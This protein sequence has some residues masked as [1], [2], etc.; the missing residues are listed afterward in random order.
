M[1]IRKLR[2]AVLAFLLATNVFAA[3]RVESGFGVSGFIATLGLGP[4][5]ARP[6]DSQ[7]LT[8][9]P[10]IQ[11]AYVPLPMRRTLQLIS[12]AE[13]TDSLVVGELFLGYH[14]LI[15]SV[16]EGQFGLAI[17]ASSQVKLKGSVYED[18]DPIFN[19]Y[20][21][22]YGIRNTRLALKAKV[23]YD[24]S[25]YDL[26]PYLSASGGLGYNHASGFTIKPKIPEEV[27]PPVFS[28]NN[29]TGFTYSFGIGLEAAV[30]V[31]WRVGIGYEFTN[32]GKS[33]LGRAMDQTVGDK[34]IKESGVQ[35]HELLVS[36]SFVA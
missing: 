30:D 20:S 31:N 21:Y 18:A 3:S 25:Y 1:R 26:F 23:L 17:G 16:V 11:K 32:W 36:L 15:N 8:L 19:N 6:G 34:S 10:D 27:D 33:A 12:T 14:S 29:E 24:P 4:G 5:W 35:V 7:I 2:V 13:G 28:N 22:T 9:Q